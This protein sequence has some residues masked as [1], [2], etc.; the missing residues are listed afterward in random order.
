MAVFSK[1]VDLVSQLDFAPNYQ[2]DKDDNCYNIKSG[3]QM[4]KTVVG[5][6]VGYCINSKFKSLT[7]LRQSLVEID[8]S[9][10]PF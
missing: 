6:T 3:R 5:Y 10:C 2:F 8:K 9:D 4:K 1:E 7:S